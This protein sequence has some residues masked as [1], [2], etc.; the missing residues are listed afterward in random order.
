MLLLPTL[1]LL[2]LGAAPPQPAADKPF[3][4]LN[5]EKGHP[6]KTVRGAD[7]S[8]DGKTLATVCDGGVL[9]LWD[10]ASGKQLHTAKHGAFDHVEFSRDGKHLVTA[11]TDRL[12]RLFDAKTGK[13]LKTFAGHTGQVYVA[14]FTPD[15]KQIVSS[16]IDTVTRVW[17]VQTG[18]QVRTLP[19]GTCYGL[20][21]SPDGKYAVAAGNNQALTLYELATGTKVRDF[22]GHTGV[23]VWIAFSND[24]R[25]IAS[26]S[27]DNHV[28]LWETRTGKFRLTITNQKNSPRAVYFAPGDRYFATTGYDGST[29]LYE[30]AS[31][32]DLFIDNSIG[33][34]GYALAISRDGRRLCAGGE[35]GKLFV[36]DVSAITRKRAA[37]AELAASA[38]DDAWK[39]LGSDNAEAAYKNVM[40]LSVPASL[41]HFAKRFTSP[42]PLTDEAKKR[43]PKLIAELGDDDEDKWRKASDEL[44]G[45]GPAILPA[46]KAAL[47]RET[48]ADVK[49]RLVVTIRRA[50]VGAA[51]E[52]RLLR[53]VEVLERIGTAE[54]VKLLRD[55]AKGGRGDAV[56]AEAKA[57][58]GRLQKQ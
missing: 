56:A 51:D 18:K 50:D 15:G 57:S 1:T 10:V 45:F 40:A 16:G 8:P 48:D 33:K 52:T 31:G 47:A 39:D 36:W 3:L 24:G 6:G 17:D 41:K 12:V 29:R 54:A 23:V 20:A 14:R 44:A 49:L 21:V 28:R 5:L 46:L 42:K 32:K 9:N 43:T 2:A 4:L 34:Q 22:P 53:T 27:Y 11:G 55:L 7:F 19:T 26:C 13:E 58:L 38:F 37:D 30:A 35:T 25:T